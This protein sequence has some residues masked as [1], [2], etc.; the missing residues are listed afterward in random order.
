MK[1]IVALILAFVLVAACAACGST[2][3]PTETT[4]PTEVTTEP[5]E[6]IE[7]TDAPTEGSTQRNATYI[8]LSICEEDGTCVSLTAYDDGAGMAH[9]E[10]VA[11]ERKVSTFE[12]SILDEIAAEI[13]K[14]QLMALNDQHV[15]EDGLASASMYVSYSDESFLGADFSGTIPQEFRD[16]YTALENWFRQLMADVP[17][18]VPRPVVEGEVDQ[19][20]LSEMEAILDASGAEPLDMFIISQVAMDDSFTAV[21]GLSK[22][23]GIV[24][25]LSCSPMMSAVAFSCMIATAESE[26]AVSA[27]ADDFAANVQWNRWICVSATDAMIATKGTQ[28]I[29]LVTTGDLYTQ[30]STAIQSTG[31]TVVQTLNN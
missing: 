5:T 17:V 20:A 11:D 8:Q 19:A 9:V 7:P 30:L 27:I 4:E 24:S 12:L 31:W 26:D 6:V 23:D 21:M 29:C 18:Y 10:Y 28:V 15:Y 3:Q 22:T 14:S 16:G 13:E 2:Q 1:K 25:G